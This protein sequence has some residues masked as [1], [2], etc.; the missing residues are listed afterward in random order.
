MSINEEL[1]VALKEKGLSSIIPQLKKRD[2][3]HTVANLI[4]DN[5]IMMVENIKSSVIN[6]LYWCSVLIDSLEHKNSKSQK[7]LI[8]HAVK[9]ADIILN[10]L[11]QIPEDQLTSN[12]FS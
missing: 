5:P 10:S 8:E 3:H 6:T 12:L 11:D 2:K 1:I 7:S 9:S 4:K